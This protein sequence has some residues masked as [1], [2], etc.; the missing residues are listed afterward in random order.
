MG[1]LAT[2]LVCEFDFKNFFIF[3]LLLSV[4]VIVNEKLVSIHLCILTLNVLIFICVYLTREK[5]LKKIFNKVFLASKKKNLKEKK[6]Q[7]R[8]KHNF[9]TNAQKLAELCDKWQF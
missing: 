9:C 5:K 3:I 7:A 2:I 1:F 4:Q 8:A 6:Y